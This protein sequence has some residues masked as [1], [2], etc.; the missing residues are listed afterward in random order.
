MLSSLLPSALLL[1]SL[2]TLTAEAWP[3]RRTEE[4]CPVCIIGAGPAGLTAAGRLEQKGIKAVIFDDQ[5][6]VGGKCQAWY[7]DQ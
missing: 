3:T 2:F 4:A 1:L 6:E 7:D 5:E